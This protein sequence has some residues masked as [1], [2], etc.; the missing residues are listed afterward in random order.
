MV[1]HVLVMLCLP[2]INDM[3]S[4]LYI[5]I[6]RLRIHARV[7]SVHNGVRSIVPVLKPIRMS[8]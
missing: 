3:S 5:V 7:T 6:S 2:L 8:S 4:A 1:H